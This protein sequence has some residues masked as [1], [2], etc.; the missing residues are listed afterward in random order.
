MTSAPQEPYRHFTL[1]KPMTTVSLKLPETLAIRLEDAARER[2]VS[3][4]GLIRSALEVYLESDDAEEPGS[5]LSRAADLAGLLCGP[6][7]SSTNKDYLE[8]FGR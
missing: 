1:G 2:G 8:N 3:T 6:E 7:D 4:S 5:A